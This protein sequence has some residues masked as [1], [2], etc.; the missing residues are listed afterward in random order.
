MMKIHSLNRNF[1]CDKFSEKVQ[2]YFYRIFMSR[3]RMQI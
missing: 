2:I 1:D 3:H